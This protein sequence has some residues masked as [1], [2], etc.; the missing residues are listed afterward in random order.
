MH[1]EDLTQPP[2]ANNG[3]HPTRCSAAVILN[4][5]GGREMQAVR[6]KTQRL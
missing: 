1:H 6:Q 4:L 2:Q 3:M 5:L